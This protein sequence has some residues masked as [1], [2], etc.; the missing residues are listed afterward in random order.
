[1]INFRSLP[2]LTSY[3]QTQELQKQLVDLRIADQIPDTILFLE[4]TPVITRGRGLQF[5]GEPRPKHLPVPANLPDGIEF[6]DCERGGDLT[7]H[8]PGQLVIYPIVKLDGRGIGPSRDITK[9]LR[10]LEQILISCLSDY[11]LKASVREN[12]TG[13]WI[14]DRKIASI[15]IAVRK[16]VT[17]HGIAI[18]VVNDLRPFHLISPC[19]F[20]PEVMTSLQ[21]QSEGKPE[22]NIDLT[23]WREDLEGRFYDRYRAATVLSGSITQLSE[24][25]GSPAGD[26]VT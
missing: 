26:L 13:V 11:G 21:E 15:G 23:K 24:G 3:A 10:N 12:A 2:G 19:G 8:G 17:Y 22:V 6:H 18:N 14:N 25:V 7:F 20:K 4:H 9:Y 5:T 1:M 16:W